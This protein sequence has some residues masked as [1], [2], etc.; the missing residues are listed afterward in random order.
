M[1]HI[2]ALI[3]RGRAE[4]VSRH[5][6][7]HSGHIRGD[8]FSRAT[9]VTRAKLYKPIWKIQF[10]M[11]GALNTTFNECLGDVNEYGRVLAPK[12]LSISVVVGSSTPNRKTSQRETS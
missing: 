1:K 12:M 7:R 6:F 3:F 2:S 10:C 4:A 5:N 11:P 8:R 9:M